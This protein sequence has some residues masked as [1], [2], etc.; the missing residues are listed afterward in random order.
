MELGG[1]VTFGKFRRRR[2]HKILQLLLGRA[3]AESE[4]RQV[5]QIDDEYRRLS[6]FF[7]VIE[8]RDA[9]QIAVGPLRE[10][11]RRTGDC[12]LGHHQPW[13]N[14]GSEKADHAPVLRSLEITFNSFG[15]R[16]PQ[17]TSPSLGSM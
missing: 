5:F 2:S 7:G 9:L 12:I 14:V 16:R 11:F 3:C 10:Q 8:R 4:K 6:R 17:A 1:T 13:P 15:L